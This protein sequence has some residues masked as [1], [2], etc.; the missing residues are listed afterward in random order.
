MK[1]IINI[2]LGVSLTFGLLSFTGV[3]SKTFPEQKR[4]YTE[5]IEN[6]DSL[7]IINSFTNCFND[8]RFT[9]KLLMEANEFHVSYTERG[10]SETITKTLPLDFKKELLEYEL[11]TDPNMKYGVGSNCMM[12]FK[13]NDNLPDTIHEC[14]QEKYYNNLIKRIKN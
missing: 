4:I 13:F 5:D 7:V 3:D 2:V 12:I 10:H 8:S 6:G 9:L 14:P 11:L 1:L